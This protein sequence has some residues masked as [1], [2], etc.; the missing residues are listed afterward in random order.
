MSMLK[1]ITILL[2]VCLQMLL[3]GVLVL[4]AL[5][6]GES[7]S[8]VYKIY[9]AV[10][11]VSLAAVILGIAFHK[12][13]RGF[14]FQKAQLFFAKENRVKVLVVL[15]MYLAVA[16][17]YFCHRPLL[18]ANFDLPERLCTLKES[19]IFIGVNPL[20]GMPE[21]EAGA[22]QTWSASVLPAFYLFWM[23][24]F[25]VSIFDMLFK[26]V[27]CFVLALSMGAY[28]EIA[29]TLFCGD[30]KK[31]LLFMLAFTLLTL[32]GNGAYM[33]PSYGLLHYAYEES[34]WMS[35]VILPLGFALV[36]RSNGKKE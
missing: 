9:G 35:S 25:H 1:R 15:A 5:L 12:P 14:V 17:T 3:F 24:V 22:L 6:L 2:V 8:F 26:M 34:T 23:K 21:A 36:L 30:E 29:K 28:Y 18:E 27:P 20:T 16:L 31:V 33:N 32:C 13:F 19:G 7:F 4:A 11:L 10:Q